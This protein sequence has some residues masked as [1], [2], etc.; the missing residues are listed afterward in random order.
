MAAPD[1]G[2]TAKVSRKV[3]NKV[4]DDNIYLY[5]SSTVVVMFI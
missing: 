5:I 1:I 4:H 2:K 3:M